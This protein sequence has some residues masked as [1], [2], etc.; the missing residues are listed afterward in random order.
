MRIV[1]NSLSSSI[2]G[3]AA[4]AAAALALVG[5]AFAS[6]SVAAPVSTNITPRTQH[7]EIRTRNVDK[8]AVPAAQQ[9]SNIIYL[10]RCVGGC[11][12]LPGNNADSRTN[13]SPIPVGTATQYEIGEFS[14]GDDKWAQIVACV[15]ESYAPYNVT[16]TDQDPGMAVIHHEAIIAGLSSDIGLPADDEGIGEVNG[17]CSPYDNGISFTFANQISAVLEICAVASQESGHTWGMDHEFICDDP[18]T[19]LDGCGQKYFRNINAQ[20]GEYAAR[21]CKCGG[22]QN[23]HQKLFDVFG[24]NP[25]P[26]ASPTV[27]LAVPSNNSTVVNGFDVLGTA[28][29]PRGISHVDLVLNGHVWATVNNPGGTTADP[30][31][32]GGGTYTLTAP[33]NV[34]DGLIDVDVVAYNDLET[35]MSTASV[36][37][38]KGS[39][40]TSATSCL[41]GQSCDSSGRCL[42]PA[43]TGNLGDACTY[44][45]F[46][47]NNTCT[48]NGSMSFCSQS[49]ITSVSTDCPDGFTCVAAADSNAG[50]CFAGGGGGGGGCNSSDSAATAG[51]IALLTLFSLLVLRRRRA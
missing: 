19:Y 20:C 5:A 30:F 23:S 38:T 25:T 26:L 8:S 6:P 12:I 22:L 4:V 21:D 50:S 15:Q 3:R 9:V 39:L 32:S 13:T 41:K 33:S 34:P 16:V 2:V 17:D 47:L 45:E 28:M 14:G 48:A 27:T 10:N 44:N 1:P 7:T 37:V 49:C 51:Q 43:A 40:C 11:R 24:P 42:W 31:S 46:C 35:T 36:T 18:M 29:T